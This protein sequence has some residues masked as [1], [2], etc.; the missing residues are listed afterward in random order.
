MLVLDQVGLIVVDLRA[1]GAIRLKEKSWLQTRDRV[2]EFGAIAR[3]TAIGLPDIDTT[4]AISVSGRVS[5]NAFVPAV[6]ACAMSPKLKCR[7]SKSKTVMRCGRPCGW[8]AEFAE[9]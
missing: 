7:S 1:V 8:A 5:A 6:L 2:L 4:A 9:M 3:Q